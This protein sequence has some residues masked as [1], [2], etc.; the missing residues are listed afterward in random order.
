MYDILNMYTL[1][2]YTIHVWLIYYMTHIYDRCH[3]GQCRWCSHWWRRFGR[4]V[5]GPLAQQ[6]LVWSAVVVLRRVVL[7]EP[8]HLHCRS[9][10]SVSLSY[11]YLYKSMLSPF[12][13]WLPIDV[14]VFA[15]RW[16]FCGYIDKTEVLTELCVLF[17]PLQT[18]HN[19]GSELDQ[20]WRVV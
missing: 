5:R 12:Y 11:S 8:N 1:Y 16:R 17:V 6:H 3:C 13:L 10:E 9:G 2:I 7:C 18:G 4:H 15:N 20:D 19:G 14:D